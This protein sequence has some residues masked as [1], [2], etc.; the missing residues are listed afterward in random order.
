MHTFIRHASVVPG[1]PF[2]PRELGMVMIIP[3]GEVCQ[4]M[5]VDLPRH[6]DAGFSARLADVMPVGANIA[7]LNLFPPRRGFTAAAPH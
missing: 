1:M 3:E 7:A 6:R 4:G 2:R 5:G